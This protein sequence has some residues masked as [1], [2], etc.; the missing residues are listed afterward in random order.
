MMFDHGILTRIATALAGPD[1]DAALDDTL[2]LLKEVGIKPANA[3]GD[4]WLIVA[5]GEQTLAF[6]TDDAVDEASRELVAG[7]VR[8]ALAR[9][10]DHAE[11]RRLLERMEMLSAAAFEGLFMH[12]NGVVLDANH[13]FAELVGYPRE[14]VIGLNVI[15]A[16]VVP[17][18]HGEVRRRLADRFEGE[19]IVTAI[20]RNGSRFRAELHSKQGR[21]GDRPVRVVAVRDVT[22]R[23]R[24][25][26]LFRESEARLR[27]LATAA[28]DVLVVSRNGIIVQVS[29]AIEKMFGRRAEDMV[30]RPMLSF[31]APASQPL[32]QTVLDEQRFGKYEAEAAHVDGT[33]IP[34][35]IFAVASTHDGQP[36]RVA[37]LRD[38]RE[39]HRVA[40]ERRK[41]EQQVERTQRL[42]S[43]GILAGGIAHDFNNLLVGIMGGADILM[44]R[45]T[46]PAD[47]EAA[48]MVLAAGKRA[49]TLTRQMLAYA[50]QKDMSRREPVDL[51][52]LWEEIQTLLGAVLS[53]KA[54]VELDI[55]PQSI[56]RGDRA[57]LMQVLMNLLTNASDALEGKPG[58]IDVRTRH[59]ETP[60]ER[61]RTALGA[62]VT[63][64]RWLLIEVHDNGVGMP[65]STLS[66]VF[67]P[68]FSTKERGHGLGLAACL[69]I[70][71]A[72]GGAILVESEPG[73]GSCFSVLLPAG[74][75]QISEPP[76]AQIVR[77]RRPCR[78]LVIDDEP[79]VRMHVRQALEPCGYVVEE[80]A[81]GKSGLAALATTSADVVLLDMVMPDIDGAEVA[82][83]VRASGSQIPIVVSTAYL[84]ATVK[85]RLPPESFQVFLR[86]PY[87]LA[88]LVDALDRAITKGPRSTRPAPR[89]SDGRAT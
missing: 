70:V 43:L 79:L 33:C 6:A 69:G 81:D 5:H 85:S 73:K 48:S 56:V 3:G 16:C 35:E 11:R 57:T 24:S 74:G 22:E 4:S 87:D 25:Q 72:H 13:R 21:I 29:G 55:E 31:V 39:R 37:G 26:L 82:R 80:A 18:H 7:L 63:S 36:V 19:Y 30:G 84:D 58:R 27:E 9:S 67:E 78:V 46:D 45:L 62:P 20:R 34:A 38:L 2:T 32:I 64:G 8:T 12:V 15:E 47:R 41:L 86:K 76:V 17:E 75:S 42:D 10:A 54:Q 44:R 23:E 60:D 65:E 1:P 66:R 88:E 51:R 59:L 68:F 89:P 61:W 49:A 83:R 40:E 50:G 52:D 28:F 53:K 14:E 77:P 71:S